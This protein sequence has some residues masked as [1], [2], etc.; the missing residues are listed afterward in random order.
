MPPQSQDRLGRIK[1]LQ[2]LQRLKSL[3]AEQ[4]P[5]FFEET[6]ESGAEEIRGF[7][8]GAEEL[9]G[10][11]LQRLPG[12]LPGQ[13]LARA[14]AAAAP[15][16]FG[17]LRD[18]FL[19]ETAGAAAQAATTITDFFGLTEPADR[20]PPESVEEA[21]EQ[22][23]GAMRLAG[24]FTGLPAVARTGQRAARLATEPGEVLQ[25]FR[26]G[27]ISATLPAALDLSII[28][29][30][31][32]IAARGLGRP[33][34]REGAELVFRGEGER[35]AER[36][37]A[38]AAAEAR[39]RALMAEIRGRISG[40]IPRRAGDVAVGPELAP[41]RMLPPAS[42]SGPPPPGLGPLRAGVQRA[43]PE[44]EQA[45]ARIQALKQQ[46]GQAR[47][48]A[49]QV[50]D[51]ATISVGPTGRA[52]IRSR[53][54]GRM[55]TEI[56]QAPLG[57]QVEQAPVRDVVEERMRALTDI[58]EQLSRAESQALRASATRA[59]AFSRGEGIDAVS[60]PRRA[61]E[62]RAAAAAELEDSRQL[63]RA[64]ME[65]LGLGDEE[66]R[67]Y[68]FA[69][70]GKQNLGQL[71]KGEL[72]RVN[73]ILQRRIESGEPL[74]LS[75]DEIRAL[76]R[77]E[78]LPK[79]RP[80]P[81]GRPEKLVDEMSPEAKGADVMD[82]GEVDAQELVPGGAVDSPIQYITEQ[83]ARRAAD[84]AAKSVTDLFKFY[85]TDFPVLVPD[86]GRRARNALKNLNRRRKEFMG[87][88]E[89]HRKA[90]QA[91][92]A[93]E[94]EVKDL[95][96]N[97]NPDPRIAGGRQFTVATE[98]GGTRQVGIDIALIDTVPEGVNPQ[99]WRSAKAIREELLR[100]GVE[101]GTDLLQNYVP[102]IHEFSGLNRIPSDLQRW[103]PPGFFN[104]HRLQGPVDRFIQ[105]TPLFD[106]IDLRLYKGW[107][108]VE[109]NPMVEWARQYSAASA[110]M[111]PLGPQSIREARRR[112]AELGQ[113]TDSAELLE[114]AD[115][116][117]SIGQQQALRPTQQ[118]ATNFFL[119]HFTNEKGMVEQMIDDTFSAV[120]RLTSAATG[121]RVT[122]NMTTQRA[123]QFLT[124][125]TFRALLGASTTTAAQNAT[126]PFYSAIRV[127]I[128][129]TVAAEAV[130]LPKAFASAATRLPA[131]IARTATGG[132]VELPV[133]IPRF[134]QSSELLS[135][136]ARELFETGARPGATG[137]LRQLNDD[138]SF[139]LFG[140]VE[141]DLNRGAGL[142]AGSLSNRFRRGLDE[143][144]D[145]GLADRPAPA[146]SRAGQIADLR[147]GLENAWETQFLYGVVDRLPVFMAGPIG[148]MFGALSSFA[149]KS[150][151]FLAE[152]VV[153]RPLKG[154]WELAKEAYGLR[155]GG[156][157]T[158]KTFGK[159]LL[160]R[161]PKEIMP[162]IRFYVMGGIMADTLRA[163][164]LNFDDTFGIGPVIQ[165]F[166]FRVPFAALA[167]VV[168]MAQ[169]LSTEASETATREQRY[170]AAAQFGEDF[171]NYIPYSA[172]ARRMSDLW[173][174]QILQ[175]G[176]RRRA[177]FPE[178]RMEALLG[179][180]VRN[181]RL[182]DSLGQLI[183]DFDGA[184]DI[185][186][187]QLD[188]E[189][190]EYVMGPEPFGRTL[191]RS[192]LAPPTT[193]QELRE[194]AN[195]IRQVVAERNLRTRATVE[196]IRGLL[197]SESTDD[198]AEGLVLWAQHP[199]IMP[200][201]VLTPQ[202]A[203][204][205]GQL[206]Q[207]Q[208]FAVLILRALSA[209]AGDDKS[210]GT[211]ILESVVGGEG[212]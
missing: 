194:L 148:R 73:Q 35:L 68:A 185:V 212:Q 161:T 159:Q 95:L 6:L 24:E 205:L 61:T 113:S 158:A 92:E 49:T 137:R 111:T 37:A 150:G 52:T 76:R 17:T 58:Q 18:F 124:R 75:A 193:D 59:P 142:Y 168:S 200:D 202:I 135:G 167:P 80:P 48:A 128:V 3:Q 190:G 177:P 20:Q 183:G 43:G 140:F 196:N 172:Q 41:R 155:P 45:T 84:D 14:A 174:T 99:A 112:A 151:R 19:P 105:E 70:T 165:P 101:E 143:V 169:W 100:V 8:E 139:G 198:K 178:S 65:R 171:T 71:D 15:R 180:T 12:E 129:P 26:E 69:A 189:T 1:R 21:L 173:R 152:Q 56:G 51:E 78:R 32:R 53:P 211:R 134:R 184:G 102:I 72:S 125:N 164:G 10:Q 121:G 154:V 176:I 157:A 181:F 4:Q 208:R 120:S 188:P 162:A 29:P 88:L 96:F 63:L 39:D 82:P 160:L 31:A 163:M 7:V 123:T 57:L 144:F 106:L 149:P 25:E 46:L 107:R 114:A 34:S 187:F 47:G 62:A 191:R 204:I 86:V 91:D 182:E 97:G 83:G 192:L 127:G 195:T 156:P 199:E 147:A 38:Q 33:L 89:P 104:P 2:R 66:V 67:R 206:N 22:V 110:K 36:A 103:T 94:A 175:D 117:E 136:T 11:P 30:T 98:G 81:R 133:Y 74:P 85:L 141:D 138:L 146:G 130:V 87:R 116:L 201:E 210:V 132:R 209:H 122:P 207:E 9:T 109:L 186:S 119:R 23:P 153:G 179:P 197:L 64:G 55:E 40:D 131:W 77:G 108:D 5:G 13:P 166:R 60:A 90:I 16:F 44:L 118:R 93:I 54:G 145:A 126:Q 50:P 42:R 27:P 79:G 115:M 203:N 170:A 28:G